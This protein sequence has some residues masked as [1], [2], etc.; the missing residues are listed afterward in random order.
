MLPAPRKGEEC[1]EPAKVSPDA[2]GLK[3]RGDGPLLIVSVSTCKGGRLYAFAPGAPLR[4]ARLADV[5]EAETLRSVRALSIRGGKRESDFAVELTA[6][7]TTTELRLF[8]SRGTGFG[9]A[10]SGTLREYAA[11]R[12]CTAGGEEGSGW[13]SHIRSEK[14]RL[15]VLRIDASCGGGPWQASCMLYRAEQDTLSHAGVCLLPPKLDAKSLKTS[16][17]K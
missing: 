8:A 7:P 1:P 15:A 3:D 4:I 14:D 10:D 2:Q 5:T 9:F 12:E 11:V 17:W 13:T 6:T 16:G